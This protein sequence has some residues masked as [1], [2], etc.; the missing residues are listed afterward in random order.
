MVVDGVLVPT[1]G[2]DLVRQYARIP[3]MT[4]VARKEWAHKKRELH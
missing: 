3:I 1:S 4:G 2:V